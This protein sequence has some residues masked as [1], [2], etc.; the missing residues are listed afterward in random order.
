MKLRICRL[1]MLFIFVTVFSSCATLMNGTTQKVTVE[2]EPTGAIVKVE[3][4]Y[5]QAKTPV[6]LHL[7]RKDGPYRLTITMDGYQ[8]YQVYIKAS[9]SGWVWGNILVGGI[10]GIAIDYS[11]G[12]ATKLDVKDVFA[13]LQRNG[14]TAQRNKEGV[15]LFRND[16]NLLLA[17]NLE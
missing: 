2:S 12:A 9:T 4:G 10:I 3:P 7:K 11:T 13:N 15:F 14:I 5:D 1:G 16:G 17:V 6:E 8:P